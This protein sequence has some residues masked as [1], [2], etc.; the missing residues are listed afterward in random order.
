M[1]EP[2]AVAMG[3]GFMSTGHGL[4]SMS[5]RYRSGSR[6]LSCAV[7]LWM[8]F[9]AGAAIGRDKKVLIRSEP[10]GAK[11]VLVGG[12]FICKAV[13]REGSNGVTPCTFSIDESA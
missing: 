7:G 2:R 6:L 13:L 1:G 4:E 8:V 12:G 5:A 11:V 10:P 9:G 3:E